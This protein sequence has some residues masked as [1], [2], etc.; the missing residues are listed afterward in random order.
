MVEVNEGRRQEPRGRTLKSARIV[1]NDRCSTV[2]CTVRNLSAHGALLLLPTSLGVPTEFELWLDGVTHLAHIVWN[3]GGKGGGNM[4][5]S[6]SLAQ[7]RARSGSSLWLTP[8]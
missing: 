2:D 7:L 3:N 6:R 1:F 8:R 5:S 4:A